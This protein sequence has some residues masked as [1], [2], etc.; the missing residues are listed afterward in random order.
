[1][2]FRLLSR[3]VREMWAER[4]IVMSK[5][6]IALLVAA[7]TGIS[8]HAITIVDFAN[9][10]LIGKIMPGTAPAT[11][12]VNLAGVGAVTGFEYL[13]LK[14]DGANGGA[15]F[16]V[17]GLTDKVQR[18]VSG[19]SKHTPNKYSLLNTTTIQSVSDG[20]NAAIMLGLGLAGMGLAY[21][22]TRS[23]V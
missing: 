1:M 14:Y 21:R 8:A 13:L 20:G 7:I 23:Q 2:G 4:E 19:P 11:G 22:K 5:K 12:I 15:I 18:P 9:T 6:I 10:G 16:N 17:T 3:H